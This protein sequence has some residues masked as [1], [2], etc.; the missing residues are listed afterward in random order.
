ME[1]E[2][3]AAVCIFGSSVRGP[4][5]YENGL[6]CQDASAFDIIHPHSVVIAV[7]DGLGSAA[8]SDVGAEAA[9]RGGCAYL[10]RRRF[11]DI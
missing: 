10:R 11:K 1:S 8:R 2:T 6:P 3:P 4:M 5:H 7:A 9:V